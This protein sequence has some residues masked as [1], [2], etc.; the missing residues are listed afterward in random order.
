MHVPSLVTIPCHLNKLS[1]GNEN[2]GV[3]RADYSVKIWW[4]LPF[5]NPKPYQCTYQ[6]CWKSID[7]Y[8][9][10]HPETKYNG[11][12]D[13]R[14]DEQT[15]GRPTW[16]IVPRHCRVAGYKKSCMHRTFRIPARIAK[17]VLCRLRTFGLLKKLE[18]LLYTVMKS[19][20]N[21]R[22]LTFTTFLAKK[23]VILY[24][25]L[26]FFFFFFFCQRIGFDISMERICMKCQSLFSGKR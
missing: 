4:N 18:H 16:T 5:S 23:L 6:V 20:P 17:I 1:S 19:F 26:P 8:S 13:W 22:K 3:S 14:T 21:S 15:H 2:M 24:F 11:R 12:T 25:L 7:V 10:Y 9:R